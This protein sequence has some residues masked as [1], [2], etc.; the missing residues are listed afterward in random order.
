MA[1]TKATLKAL[2][3]GAPLVRV[4]WNYVLCLGSF[5]TMRFYQWANL[6]T[7]C[8]INRSFFGSFDD[9]EIFVNEQ[10]IN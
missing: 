3:G 6:W 4:R 8:S 1:H 10:K 7:I 5:Y 9:F 2:R